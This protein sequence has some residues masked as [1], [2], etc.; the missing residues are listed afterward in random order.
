MCRDGHFPV[1]FDRG[2]AIANLTFD[3]IWRTD[4]GHQMLVAQLQFLEGLVALSASLATIH[5]SVRLVT[6]LFDNS[7][8]DLT[9]VFCH[10]LLN[11]AVRVVAATL[12]GGF[13][14]LQGLFELDG[15]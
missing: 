12:H 1:L 6:L 13:N 14:F 10:Q 11:V 8:L 4:S 7:L 9:K 3:T 2:V 15:F 5:A